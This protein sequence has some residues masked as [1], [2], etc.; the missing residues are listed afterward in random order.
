M[1]LL[2]Q[3]ATSHPDTLPFLQRLWSYLMLGATAIITEEATPLIGGLAAQSRRLDITAVG[4]WIAS[5]TWT[6]GFGLYYVGRLH[7]HWARKRWP[8]IRTMMLTAF[9]IVRRH[10][11]R[12]SLA[13]RWAF[14]MRLTLPIA[15][16]AARLPLFIY[17]IGSAISCV[18]WSFTFVILG[19]GFGHT[20]LIALGHVRRYEKYLIAVIVLALFVVFRVMRRKHVEDDVV[21]VLAKGDTDPA[22]RASR[23][24]DRNG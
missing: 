2:L 13:V 20:V 19:W 11:W 8:R 23:P 18:T 12:A 5:G 21:G 9:K 16:G 3:A 15:C 1:S 4:L 24:A 7:G 10:P 17:A 6:A 14:G 22:P